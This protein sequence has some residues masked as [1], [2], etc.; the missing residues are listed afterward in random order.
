[1]LSAPKISTGRLIFRTDCPDTRFF[2]ILDRI[3]L[4]TPF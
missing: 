2:A 4:R 3:N 1:L